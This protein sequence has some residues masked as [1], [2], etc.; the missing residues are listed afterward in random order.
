MYKMSKILLPM[1][2]SSIG[3]GSAI[4]GKAF[5][6]VNSSCE[7]KLVEKVKVESLIQSLKD[8]S[9]TAKNK[10]LNQAVLAGAIAAYGA[11]GVY[12]SAFMYKKP[13]DSAI[14]G[15][16]FASTAGYGFSSIPEYNKL[17][18]EIDK[19]IAE[20][21]G[22]SRQNEIKVN[23]CSETTMGQKALLMETIKNQKSI[24][25]SAVVEL[26][27]QLDSGLPTIEITQASAVAIFL[28]STLGKEFGFSKKI[29]LVGLGGALG[30][31]TAYVSNTMTAETNRENATELLKKLRLNLNL[32]NAQA[33]A[34]AELK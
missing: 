27:K 23:V 26:Q 22:L 21:E 15:L 9:E 24:T 31:A 34:L 8:A 10:R 14:I 11:A 30:V 28:S 5:A 18:N 2:I 12:R 7:L 1:I 4:P 16:I 32:L 3:L 13:A 6:E 33:Q 17:I 25:E 29:I 19:S 20:F